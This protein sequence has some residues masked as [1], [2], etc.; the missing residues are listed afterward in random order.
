MKQSFFTD[1][2]MQALRRSYIVPCNLWQKEDEDF[3]AKNILPPFKRFMKDLLPRLKKCDSSINDN[4]NEI[5]VTCK[6]REQFALPDGDYI[7]IG[8]VIT[9]NPIVEGQPVAGMVF[10]FTTKKIVLVG[11]MFG[12][13]NGMAMKILAFIDEKREK[14]ELL[15]TN[16]DFVESFGE[17]GFCRSQKAIYQSDNNTGFIV[18]KNFAGCEGEIPARFIT[19]DI[20][21]EIVL[22]HY[23]GVKVVN[24]FIERALKP[25]KHAYEI[26]V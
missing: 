1:N 19:D 16:E 18:T 12:V 20:L 7:E 2:F 25:T 10:G 24:R 23:K 21:P 11:G 9:Q 22:A 14:Y 6:N 5:L 17:N 15:A 4:L 8:A 3:Y 13:D 26:T